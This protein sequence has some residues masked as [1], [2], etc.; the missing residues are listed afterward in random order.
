[1]VQ[2]L[3]KERRS[4]YEKSFI[5]L[6]P[7][8]AFAPIIRS[9]SKSRHSSEMSDQANEPAATVEEGGGPPSKNTWPRGGSGRNTKQTVPL[10]LLL[11]QR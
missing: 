11:L 4:L 7:V 6:R 10:S 1:M 8:A 3:L 2:Y 9:N 5:H